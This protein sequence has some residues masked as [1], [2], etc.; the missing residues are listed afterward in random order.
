MRAAFYIGD[1]TTKTGKGR[2]SKAPRDDITARELSCLG[3]V[4]RVLPP[5]VMSAAVYLDGEEDTLDVL[6]RLEA[7]GLLRFVAPLGLGMP[8]IISR[9]FPRGD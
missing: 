1:M 8:A 9:P 7:R 5:G 2:R 6:S 3:G 4:L